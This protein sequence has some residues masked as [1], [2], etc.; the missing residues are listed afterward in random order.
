MSNINV[1]LNT[2]E[3][4][5]I[6]VAL[7]LYLDD[8]QTEYGAKNDFRVIYD[9]LMIELKDRFNNIDLSKA[10]HRK[11]IIAGTI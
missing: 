3:L 9:R 10:N 8:K 4:N 7:Q 5:N 1:K 2:I 11:K 6:C